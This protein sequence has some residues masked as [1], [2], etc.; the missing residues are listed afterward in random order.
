MTYLE[1]DEVTFLSAPV[2]NNA[3]IVTTAQTADA[4]VSNVRV[5]IEFDNTATPTLNTDLTVEVTCNGG[6]NWASASLSA[7]DLRLFNQS[8]SGELRM[9]EV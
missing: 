9:L 4:S 3:T 5:L 2:S 8:E 7:V 6:S 1:I